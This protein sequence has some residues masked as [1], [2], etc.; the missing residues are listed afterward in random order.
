MNFKMRTSIYTNT[1]S[2]IAASLLFAFTSVA[3]PG[4]RWKEKGEK[5]QALKIA[6]ITQEL[7]LAP[8]E[9]QNFW[10]LYNEMEKALAVVR[11]DK[12]NNRVEAGMMLN[13]DIMSD[14]EIEEALKLEFD[15]TEKEL[16]IRRSYFEKFKKVLP[17]RKVALL[18]SA[19]ERFKLKLL[20]ELRKRREERKGN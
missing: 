7:D 3:Q 14:T 6:F 20:N 10:P 5:I 11:K 1:L 15:I 16:T 17:M 4:Q 9:A 13:L 18:Y 2:L 12:W 8:E 19:E